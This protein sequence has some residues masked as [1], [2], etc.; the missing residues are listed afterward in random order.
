MLQAMMIQ[1]PVIGIIYGSGRERTGDLTIL[2]HRKYAFMPV[3]K[4]F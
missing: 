4:S 2:S 1:N 3:L